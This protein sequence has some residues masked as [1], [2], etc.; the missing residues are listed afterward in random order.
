MIRPTVSCGSTAT[1]CAQLRRSRSGNKSVSCRRTPFFFTTRSLIISSSAGSMR[2][3]KKS[4]PRP[5][6][7]MPM[8]SSWRNRKATRRSS[9]TKAVSFPADNNSVSRS[10]A[11]CSR[12]RPFFSSTKR[13]QRSIP[14]PNNKSSS[15]S[16]GLAQGRTVIAIAHRL[17]TILSADQIVVMEKGRIKEIG[18]HARVARKLRLLSPPL[19]SAVQPQS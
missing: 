16:N 19:R 1:I 17:S 5:R 7:P 10:P 13:R 14:S 2:R 6:P 9:A 15:R 8:T 4:K 3:R 18:T 11:H 12:T